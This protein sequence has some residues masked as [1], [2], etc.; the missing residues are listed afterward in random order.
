MRDESTPPRDARAWLQANGHA[1]VVAKIDTLQGR[2]A[3]QGKK[4]RRNWWEVLAG[5]P[6][7]RPRRVDGVVFPVLEEARRRQAKRAARVEPARANGRFDHPPRAVR[8]PSPGYP[9]TA[10]KASAPG[11]APRRQRAV[12]SSRSQRLQ[13]R[14]FLKWAG[15]KR[16]LLDEI[17]G[18]LPGEIGTF[19]EPFVGGGAVFFAL[20][21]RAAILSDR[22]ER[23][24]R[25]YRG[26]R[27][28]VDEVIAVLRTCRND[29]RF[30]LAMREK[31]VDDRSDAEVAAW[32]IYLNKT[33]YNGLYRVNSKNQFNVPF[34]DNEGANLCDESNLRACA[35]ALRGADLHC[36]DFA[37]VL[38][39]ARPGDVVYFDPPYVPL[40]VTSYFTSYT[41]DGF[42]KDDQ[43]R[44]RDVALE[45]KRRGV[46]VLLSNS[47]APLV[48]Q[49][50]GGEFECIEVSASR[51]VNS[52]ASGRGRITEL[53][54]R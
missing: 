9:T 20:Q 41:K 31:A 5:G 45:L 6:G 32:L 22:N 4:T 44:L 36:E 33:G 53:L 29:K 26:V 13:A 25:A 50:Y 21:P 3:R 43:V 35:A 17:L 16:Q 23:L 14:P 46:F 47:A 10:V 12:R 42:E 54:I 38:G 48:R 24:I 15:G 28:S 2:W 1:D 8:E 37:A 18:R 34:G 40:S 19:H 52:V 51:M 27:N 39:R 30:F 49:L 11:A 7:G